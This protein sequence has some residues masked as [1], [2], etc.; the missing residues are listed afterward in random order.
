MKIYSNEGVVGHTTPK[1]ADVA[2]GSCGQ[3]QETDFF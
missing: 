1:W 2:K 3:D